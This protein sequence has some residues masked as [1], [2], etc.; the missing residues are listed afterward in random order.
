MKTIISLFDHS[1]TWAM[2]FAEAGHEV[3]PFDLDS[4][5]WPVD[6]SDLC[7]GWLLEND[8]DIVDG[9]LAAPPCTDFTNSGAQYWQRKDEDG[10]TEASLQLAYQVIR[11]VDYFKPDF[12]VLENPVGRLPR[13]MPEIGKP[14]LIFDPCD[15]AGWVTTD[16]ERERLD[17]LRHYHEEGR[18]FTQ[19]DL[20][21]IKDTGAYTKR[22]C[23]WG[24][25][26]VPQKRR[27]EPVRVCNQGSWLQ[28]LGGKSDKTKRARS[29]TPWG[30]SY[31]F[32]EANSW[33]EQIDNELSQWR[34]A[35]FDDAETEEPN[36]FIR[37]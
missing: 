29:D 30:F 23:L 11:A 31:A 9:I 12:W 34:E 22:T 25:F 1:H 4:E 13:L 26:N 2:P 21:L 18:K 3:I 14:R 8:F 35:Q 10:R 36:P 17:E 32:A 5:D 20:Q 19:E 37:P 24:E 33:T 28:L 15:Y 16:Q 6:I 7:V 27:I